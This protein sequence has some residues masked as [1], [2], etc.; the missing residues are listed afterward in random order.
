MKEFSFR[1]RQESIKKMKSQIFDMLVIGGGITG[2][3]VARDA[4]MRGL[5]V[6]LVEKSD[7]AEG[8]SSRSTKLAHGGFRYLEN[9]EFK[10][11]FEALSERTN[12][13]KTVPHMVKPLKFYFPVYEGDKH[14]RLII[15]LGMWLYDILALFR[16]PGFHKRLSKKGVLKDFPFL[17]SKGLK[18][19]FKYYDASMWDDA[20]TVEVMRDAHSKGAEVVNYVEAVD[21]I[22]NNDKLEGFTV[23]DH[24]ANE[25][26]VIQ[27]KK[28]V[29]CAGPWTDI[30]GK[31]IS[32]DWQPWLSP[33]KG[34]H[35]VFDL[36]KIPVPGAIVMSHPEDGRI[37]F[38]IPREDFGDGVVIVGTT[39]GPTPEDPE[40]AEVDKA[41]VDYLLK[42]LD[43]YFPGI[44]VNEEDILSAYVGV[45]PLISGNT[46]SLQK[47]S[48]EHYIDYGPGGCVVV[49]GGKYTTHRTMAAEV[50]DFA[51]PKTR[52]ADTKAPINPKAVSK[53]NASKNLVNRFGGEAEDVAKLSDDILEAELKFE[54]KNGMV[55][56]LEDFFIRRTALFLT[57]KDGGISLA[58]KLAR[59]LIEEMD[60]PP[61]DIEVEI[62]KLKKEINLRNRWR[63]N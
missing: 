30:V 18:G 25:L 20:L 37:S 46:D 43:R 3:A 9:Y 8:T 14:G 62:D 24:E 11:V 42:L 15:N 44:E 50:V 6:A 32:K 31:R 45:R 12:L 16:A 13:L 39:D 63:A 51:F 55:I 5:K 27:A 52:R 7:F 54:I 1:S 56:H 53:S 17:K 4:A 2:A 58:K 21:P 19:G 61:A 49:A 57:R 29:V 22:F 60:R 33:S 47:V 41:D 48:R 38:V 23:K 35:L 59:V 34:V 26:F 10:L 36:K 40:K 28:T